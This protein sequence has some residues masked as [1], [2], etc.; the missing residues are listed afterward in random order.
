[1]TEVNIDSLNGFAWSAVPPQSKKSYEEA[2]KTIKDTWT[3]ADRLG[4]MELCLPMWAV[5]LT[6]DCI[7]EL[8][9]ELAEKHD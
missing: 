5:Q 3:L 1:M 2:I 8:K 4:Q 6:L 9:N 7:E